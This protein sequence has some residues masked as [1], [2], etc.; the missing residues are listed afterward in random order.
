MNKLA[1]DKGITLVALVITI[2]VLLILAT[3]TA[4]AGRDVISN[5]KLTT[6]GTELHAIQ[7]EVNRLHQK[8]KNGDTQ[9]AEI[10]QNLQGSQKEAKAFAGAEVT[11][12]EGY[13]YYSKSTLEQLGLKDFGQEFLV[14]IAQSDVISLDGFVYKGKT[15]WN[16]AQL[17]NGAYIVKPETNQQ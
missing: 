11:N 17:S 5:A 2:I 4:T 10:G 12:T 8:Y 14:N 16:L 15:I 1:N 13:K 7:T 9:V 6:F 3:I